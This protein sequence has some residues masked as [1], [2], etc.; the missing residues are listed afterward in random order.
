MKERLK[1]Y[2]DKLKEYGGSDLHLSAGAK[3]H[4]R[5][6]ADLHILGNEKLTNEEMI[7]IAKKILPTGKYDELVEAEEF[8]CSYSLYDGRRFRV[9]FFYQVD[10]LSAV[11]RIIP[12]N[13]LSLDELHLPPVVKNL[14]DLNHGLVLI[15]GVTRSGKTTT[16]AAII[17]RIN[18]NRKKH[19]ITIEDPIEYVHENIKSLVSQRAVGINTRSFANA[20]RS[21]LR[22]DID[23]VMVGELRDLETVR[24]A[25]DAANT[26]HL[27][28]ATLHTH[29]AKES[30]NRIIGMFPK[31]EQDHVRMTLS[32]VLEGVVSQRLVDT[33]DEGRTLAVEVMRRTSRIAELILENRDNEILEMMIRGKETYGSQSFDQSL[34]DSYNQG[35]I[36]EE[37]ALKNATVPSD[38]K[39]M[40]QESEQVSRDGKVFD[41]ETVLENFIDL[42]SSSNEE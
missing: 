41:K 15:T 1:L 26:G 3:I 30:I 21:A 35:K 22:E 7:E 12:K 37:E 29:D 2:L 28:F 32:F 31:E 20:L 18:Q 11:I 9:N 36:S 17:D 38:L 39:L 42:K 10:G 19:I 25:I 13:I 14:A 23:V 5:I 8:D 16:L 40:I 34:L 24:M 6:N 33:L 4:I 27:V